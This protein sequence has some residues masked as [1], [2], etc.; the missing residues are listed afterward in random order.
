MLRFLKESAQVEMF[1]ICIRL[2]A[3]MGE[4]RGV[5][6]GVGKETWGKETIWETQT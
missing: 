6:K 1:I 4:E 2:R 3:R 5:H